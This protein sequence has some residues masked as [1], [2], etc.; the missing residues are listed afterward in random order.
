MEHWLGKNEKYQTHVHQSS[1]INM[2]TRI[3][4]LFYFAT[5]VS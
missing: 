4:R 2:I 3:P 1:V 5:W